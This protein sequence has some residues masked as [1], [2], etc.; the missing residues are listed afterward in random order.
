MS[1]STA[2]ISPTLHHDTTSVLRK[3]GI[4]QRIAEGIAG[5]G[6]DVTESVKGCE[7][8]AKLV[9]FND[10]TERLLQGHFAT[11]RKLSYVPSKGFCIVDPNLPSSAAPLRTFKTKK[12]MEL[13]RA[14]N[15]VASA[16]AVHKLGEDKAEVVAAFALRLPQVV[17]K[18]PRI[19]EYKFE[20]EKRREFIDGLEDILLSEAEA[21]QETFQEIFKDFKWEDAEPQKRKALLRLVAENYVRAT[22]FC[23]ISGDSDLHGANWKDRCESVSTDVLAKDIDGEGKKI[24]GEEGGQLCKPVPSRD[25]D[26]NKGACVPQAPREFLTGERGER[27]FRSVDQHTAAIRSYLR[28]QTERRRKREAE[29]Y[30]TMLG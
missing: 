6:G 2:V 15:H 30:K 8:P 28:E 13:D 26:P 22:E 12:D 9:R 17:E 11:Q 29:Q 23:Y 20:W 16:L 24:L 4:P 19:A 3:A 14:L 7:A 5:R 10:V 1:S 21:H 18:L 27:E 25:G